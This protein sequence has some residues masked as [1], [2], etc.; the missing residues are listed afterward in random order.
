MNY[1]WTNHFQ[2]VNKKPRRPSEEQPHHAFSTLHGY[3]QQQQLIVP[4]NVLNS[5]YAASPLASHLPKTAKII[6]VGPR[7]GLQNEKKLVPTD[8][9]IELINRLSETG[10]KVIEATSFVSPKWVPQMGDNADVYQGIDRRPG[11]S[12]PVL[13]PNIKGLEKALEC[14]VEEIAIF[15]AASNSFSLKNIN[16]TIE[17]SVQRYKEVAD[18]AHQ[19]KLRVRGY[20]SCV[21]GCPYEG[22]IPPEQVE[23]VSRHLIED[24]GCYEVSLGDTIGTATPG[25]TLVVLQ[26]VMKTIPADKIAVHFHNTYGQ[27]LANIALALQMGVSAIDSSVAG[28]GGCPYAKGA[29]GNIATE[30]VVY[31]LHGMGISTGVDLDKLIDAGNYISTFLN[32]QNNSKVAIAVLAKREEAMKRQQN[33]DDQQQQQQQQQKRRDPFVEAVL[34]NGS[35]AT[36]SSR[37]SACV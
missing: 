37:L 6:E 22:Y 12:Y 16:C 34:Q 4:P 36:Q 2:T 21:G 3:H 25:T 14:G 8:V 24:M 19:N 30:D 35:S 17:E 18:F 10:L 1:S 28:L 20:V 33:Q 32:R 23:L 11:V 15:L 26:Q 5:A 13:T 9:K 27:A 29:S 31:M 7:D